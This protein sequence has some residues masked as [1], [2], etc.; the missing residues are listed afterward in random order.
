MNDTIL[1]WKKG[2]GIH[3]KP[4]NKGKFTA[5][6][7]RTGKTAEQLAH[8]KNPLTRKRAIFALNAR[9]WKH[10]K[11]GSI[12]MGDPMTLNNPN[13]N[14]EK[15]NLFYDYLISSGLNHAQTVGLMGNLAVESYL[16]AEQKQHNGPAYGLMQAEG[17]RQKAIK[18]YDGS[19]YI[20]GG[21]LTPQEQLQL[22]YIIDKGIQ[23][24]TPGEW[25][26]KGY[27][28][29]RKAREAFLNETDPMKASDTITLNFLRPSKQNLYRRRA[30]TQYYDE[31]QRKRT[32]KSNKYKFVPLKWKN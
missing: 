17:A 19:T 26:K 11:G 23:T 32:E 3:I 5:T 7:K 2:S 15:E 13:Y 4:E 30:M 12:A 27:S 28:G 29:A 6:M 25:G 10:Q 20:F 14:K 21:G 9:K 31:T 22:D 1:Y 18:N 24:Y 8:S 16:N